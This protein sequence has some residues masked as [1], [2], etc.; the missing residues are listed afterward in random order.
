MESSRAAWGEANGTR[1]KYQE[2]NTEI[3]D[4]YRSGSAVAE[5][6]ERYHLSEYSIRKILAG[7]RRETTQFI[8]VTAC[9]V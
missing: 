8:E 3:T 9:R 5:L 2:R 7:C 6:A 4:L 1:E